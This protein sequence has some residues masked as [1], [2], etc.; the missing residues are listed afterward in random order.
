MYHVKRPVCVPNIEEE[1]VRHWS[2]TSR[3]RITSEEPLLASAYDIISELGKHSNPR[4]KWKAL[5][6]SGAVRRDTSRYV[7]DK[8][9]GA[10]PAVDLEGCRTLLGALKVSVPASQMQELESR[11]TSLQESA[12][13]SS[14]MMLTKT[15]QQLVDTVE[16][17]RSEI[18]NLKEKKG[19]SKCKK[20][21][22]VSSEV[23]KVRSSEDG[24]LMSVF[25][26]VAAHF[27]TWK[28]DR[29]RRE[30]QESL[31]VLGRAVVAT[32]CHVAFGTRPTTCT[33]HEG[34]CRVLENV[35]IRD[36]RK[37]TLTRTESS[38]SEAYLLNGSMHSLSCQCL[39]CT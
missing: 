2:M 5:L 26:F 18:R 37:S 19:A 23:P 20:R 6:E 39:D 32:Q 11:L 34:A 30:V 3:I 24:Q 28:R 14:L 12:P 15:V 9:G 27:H 10:T 17:L 4:R 38:D 29:V 8:R 16:S 25:D 7:F 33:S 21:T 31:R 1:R 22:P 36:A 35:K 13:Q